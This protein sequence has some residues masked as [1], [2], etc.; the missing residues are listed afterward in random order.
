[1][2]DKIRK[3]RIALPSKGLL[4]EGSKKLLDELYSSRRGSPRKYGSR[5]DPHRRAVKEAVQHMRTHN[6]R[7]DAQYVVSLLT[8]C[9]RAVDG[10]KPIPLDSK[11][12]AFIN[13]VASKSQFYAQYSA[14]HMHAAKINE[15][16]VE[17]AKEA[18]LA[19]SSDHKG[20]KTSRRQST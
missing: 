15:Q 1:M 3:I 18:K 4:A 7:E 10:A 20:S 8:N 13:T 9:L 17:D 5:K 6:V 16:I 12:A 14:E 2:D 19:K 11:V